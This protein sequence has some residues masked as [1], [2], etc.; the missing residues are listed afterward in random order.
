MVENHFF[1]FFL[2]ESESLTILRFPRGVGEIPLPFIPASGGANSLP[3]APPPP[4][5]RSGEGEAFLPLL[6]DL[7]NILKIDLYHFLFRFNV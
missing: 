6:L 5:S 7:K 4:P 1:I 2:P 3:L